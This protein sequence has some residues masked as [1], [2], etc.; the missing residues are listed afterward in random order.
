M[1]FSILSGI[2]GK[3]IAGIVI[4]LAIFG[5][6]MYIRYLQGENE[7]LRLNQA[8]LEDAVKEQKKTIRVLNDHIKKVQKLTNELR[9]GVDEAISNQKQIQDKLARHDLLLLSTKKPGL[10]E[11]RI[12]DGTRKVFQDLENM[13]K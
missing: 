8:R 5:L 3:L 4:G 6:F 13:T 9:R 7:I 1:I 12:N 10:I 11:K 2:K